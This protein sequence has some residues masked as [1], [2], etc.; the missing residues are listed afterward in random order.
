MAVERFGFQIGIKQ[1]ERECQSG[2][3]TDSD[4]I[5]DNRKFDRLTHGM[6]DLLL[7]VVRPGL[8]FENQPVIPHS[9]TETVNTSSE[10]KG[11]AS[12]DC[13]HPN[14]KRWIER[15]QGWL[16]IHD[17][18]SKYCPGTA[19]LQDGLSKQAVCIRNRLTNAVGTAGDQERKK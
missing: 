5:N 7:G 9:D 16:K 2:P 19:L 13:S 6:L 10:F 15:G 12:L 17:R 14:P 11:D 3:I 4:V 8:P 1:M 18:R